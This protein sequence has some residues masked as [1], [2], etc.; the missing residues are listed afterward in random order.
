MLLYTAVYTRI[1]QCQQIAA[2]PPPC[3]TLA[4]NLAR[5]FSSAF[6]VTPASPMAEAAPVSSPITTRMIPRRRIEGGMKL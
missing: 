2:D 3:A 5:L 6:A 1:L 4:A